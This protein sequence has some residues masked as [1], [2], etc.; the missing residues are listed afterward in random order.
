MNRKHFI[1][2]LTALSGAGVWLNACRQTPS[3]PS[4]IT[5]ADA[6]T[7]HLLRQPQT[8]TPTTVTP[9][10]IAIVG[11]GVSGLSAARRLYKKGITDFALLDLD[12][13]VGGNARWDHNE[14]SA[15]PCGAHYIPIPNNTLT[16]YHDFLRE[17]DVITGVDENG[18]PVY[19]E[20]HLCFDPEERLFINGRWQEGLVP[21]F[22]VPEA[23]KKQIDAFLKEMNRFRYLTG[24]DGKEAFA[25]P[26]DRSSK[27]PLLTRLDQQT[28][29]QWMEQQGYTS[30]YLQHYI[31]YC[32]RDDYGTTIRDVS[33][34]AGI[35]YFASR[36]GKGKNVS[37]ADVLTWPE[38]NGFLVQQ[39]AKDLSSQIHTGCLAT[40]VTQ[41][42]GKA[43]IT[44]FDTTAKV[45][46]KLVADQCIV[47][48][49]QYI[50]SKL[51]SD[52]KRAVWVK[53]NLHYVPWMVAALKVKKMEERTGIAMSWDNV[54]YDS[55]S[56]GFVDATHQSLEQY[57]PKKNLV[58]YLPLTDLPPMEARKK[59]RER[60][61]NEWTQL[62]IADLKK[63]YPDLENNIED[64]KITLWGHAMV[65]PLPGM[66]HGPVRE[67][68]AAGIGS[69]IH[70]ANSDLAGVSIFE[71][72]FYQGWG[73]AEKAILQ[74]SKNNRS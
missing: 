46:R 28:M 44:Y 45:Y 19:N 13:R 49:P 11:G 61:A 8:G 5:G 41:E 66:I 20:R 43:H 31:N 51:I 12:N 50:V 63:V 14:V 52:T 29:Y 23:E 74:L 59:A 60:T 53:E 27:D 48:V 17:A 70:F 34:W 35:H 4:T 69:N 55:Q 24:A 65:Q 33:A 25:I 56:L 7:G 64:V 26:I 1:L 3:F 30:S 32:C 15:Y 21:Q 62:I 42:E 73:A 37:Y 22:G 71:E 67:R 58:Y 38:G 39:L 18:L 68:L 6:A 9:V 47:A 16:E 10:K 40:S 72:A 57:E 36:K 54:L 2:Q